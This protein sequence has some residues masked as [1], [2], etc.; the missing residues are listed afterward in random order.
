MNQTVPE[1]LQEGRTTVVTG[2]ALGIGRAAAL[3]F[4]SLGLNVV[5]VDLPSEDFD[6]AVADVAAIAGNDKVLGAPVSVTDADGMIVL[7]R[8]VEGR[9]GAPALL[10]NNAVTRVG[11]GVFAERADWR[12]AFEVN[13][14]GVINGVDAFAP[15]MIA[16]GAPAHIVNVGSKQGI[17]NPPGNAAYNVT[18]AAVRTYT[19]ALQHDLRGREGCHVSAHLLVPGWT[20]TGKREHRPGAWLPDQVIE[21]LLAALERGDFYIICPDD[22]VTPEMD[23]KRILWAAG[24]LT[25]NRP[26]LSRWHPEFAD[27]FER[28]SG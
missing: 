5:M 24:D 23:R 2:A 4:A 9:F 11:G 22:D 25:E 18:K 1:A 16:K 15:A 6:A 3:R 21:L 10:M 27:A 20:T 12:Q 8:K 28:F 19:E 7:A 14:W 17:T 26:A 13:L